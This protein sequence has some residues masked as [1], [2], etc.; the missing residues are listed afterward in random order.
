MNNL[1]INSYVLKP[2]LSNQDY[3]KTAILYYIQEIYALTKRLI[4]QVWRR[5]ATV[6]TGI[7]Q[8]LLW[9]LLFS[10]LF[11]N[12]P[13]G[14]LTANEQ[15]GDFVGPG[16]IVFTAFTCSLNAGLPL[17]F[18]REFGFL[19]RLLI[20][21]LYSRHSIIFASSINIII[22]SSLQVSSVIYICF[23]MGN[24]IPNLHNTFLVAIT[25]LLISNSITSLSL[26]LAF[27]LPGHVELLACLLIINL[28]LLF[29]STAL[30]PLIFMPSWLQ[31]IASLNPLSY[32]IEIVR[33]AYNYPTC[34]Y[35]SV[36][37]Q[38]VWGS[39][40]IFQILSILFVINILSSLTVFRLISNKF[41]E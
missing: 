21:P 23:C 29:S 41:E 12:A 33:H 28:P 11:Q 36:I 3:K 22:T 39:L 37:M 27:I 20:A 2:K 38:T 10:A 15:Y 25:L 4:F 1:H 7:I 17:I 31:V 34:E 32:A 26:I 35:A 13:I 24:Q 19:N 18:D 6:M 14:L 5:P 8:P 16:I 30:A 9:L 40:N